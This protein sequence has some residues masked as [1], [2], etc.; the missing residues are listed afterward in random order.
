MTELADEFKFRNREHVMDKLIN[1][2]AV[3]KR[4]AWA[5]EQFLDRLD[6]AGYR[7]V[8]KPVIRKVR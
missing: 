8:A 1:S 6:A 7:V 3:A 4:E 2:G 5:W